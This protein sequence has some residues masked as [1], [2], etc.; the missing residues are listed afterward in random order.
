MSKRLSEWPATA[1][2][3]LAC[4]V[5]LLL[6]FYALS[7]ANL[8]VRDGGGSLP[9]PDAVLWKYYGRADRSRLHEVLDFDLPDNHPRAMW[10]WI[11]LP[12]TKEAVAPLRQK[13]LD[14]V[15]AGAPPEGWDDVAPIFTSREACAQCHF[16]GGEKGDV[17]LQTYEDV[18]VVAQRSR[19]LSLSSLLVSA[20]NHVFAFA[21]LA[22]LLALAVTHTAVRARL[23]TLLVV[24]AF[25]GAAL[26]VGAW[27]LTRAC[28][29]PWQYA[30]ILG[31]GLFG[32]C[33]LA[34]AAL[35]FDEAVWR[36]RVAARFGLTDGSRTTD[37]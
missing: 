16:V 4:F 14:W 9:G 22:L 18:L 7:Q 26:D 12:P 5:L 15:E 2:V 13:I 25:G 32:A 20:H 23:K 33:V 28:G 29:S 36:G 19:G 30:V 21:V 34:M 27:F 37:G 6:G 11:T 8:W 3:A 10:P 35:T 1:R 24:G 31:G 17:P